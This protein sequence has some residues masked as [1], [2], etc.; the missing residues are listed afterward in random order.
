MNYFFVEQIVLGDKRL[1]YSFP[2]VLEYD[3]AKQLADVIDANKK[4]VNLTTS[5]EAT[6]QEIWGELAKTPI[7]R[8]VLDA[9]KSL[10]KYR[11]SAEYKHHDAFAP[12]A[13]K[14]Q[15][16][17][18]KDS[19]SQMDHYDKQVNGLNLAAGNM[20]SFKEFFD[21]NNASKWRPSEVS[22]ASFKQRPA[23]LHKS[24]R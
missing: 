10:I 1:G 7:G 11:I 16:P 15:R 5:R 22:G 18:K 21:P 3:V 20:P 13:Y 23:E 4:L 8:S 2:D 14:Q 6:S 19:T 17:D 12:D 24:S 9:N